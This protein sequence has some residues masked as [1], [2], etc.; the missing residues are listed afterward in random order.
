MALF[1]AQHPC[2]RR[3][4]H[5]AVKRPWEGCSSG[6]VI[7]QDTA[8]CQCCSSSSRSAG[9]RGDGVCHREQPGEMMVCAHQELYQTAIE[10]LKLEK[11]EL[12]GVRGNI[13][14]SQLFRIYEEVSE[15]SKSFADCKYDPLDPAE[16]VSEWYGSV[17]KCYMKKMGRQN[18]LEELRVKLPHNSMCAHFGTWGVRVQ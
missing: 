6:A 12:G 8:L 7:S 11:A 3:A 15:L 9:A 5:Q 14:G 17:S 13:L 18:M 1:L 10:F 4:P 2:P 16:E